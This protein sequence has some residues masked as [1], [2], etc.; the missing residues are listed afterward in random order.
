MQVLGRYVDLC[1]AAEQIM[2][3]LFLALT[4]ACGR[5]GIAGDSGAGASPKLAASQWYRRHVEAERR[6]ESGVREKV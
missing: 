1:Y 2:Q 5:R 6:S 3:Q 4:N